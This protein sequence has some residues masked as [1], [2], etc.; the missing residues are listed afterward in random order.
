MLL[1]SITVQSEN[2]V[3]VSTATSYVRTYT[4]Y[5]GQF[6]AESDNAQG[7]LS[8]TCGTTIRENSRDYTREIIRNPSTGACSDMDTPTLV[9]LVEHLNGEMRHHIETS[10]YDFSTPHARP[11]LIGI[12]YGYPA[13]RRTKEITN[14]GCDMTQVPEQCGQNCDDEEALCKASCASCGATCTK[15]K[16]LCSSKCSSLTCP[17]YWQSTETNYTAEWSLRTEFTNYLTEMSVPT[18]TAVQRFENVFQ[19]KLATENSLAESYGLCDSKWTSLTLA[20]KT[21]KTPTS[22]WEATTE[23]RNFFNVEES[24]VAAYTDNVCLAYNGGVAVT[25]TGLLDIRV[26][27]S[28]GV[29]HSIRSRFLDQYMDPTPGFVFENY[30]IAANENAYYSLIESYGND[31]GCN[32]RR[33][34]VDRPKDLDPENIT[35]INI[36][37]GS[38]RDWTF[39]DNTGTNHRVTSYNPDKMIS[40]THVDHNGDEYSYKDNRDDGSRMFVTPDKLEKVIRAD[41]LVVYEWEHPN[42]PWDLAYRTAANANNNWGYTDETASWDAT[43]YQ[44][45]EDWRTAAYTYLTQ[46]KPDTFAE[47]DGHN[48]YVV[49][50]VARK[51]ADFDASSISKDSFELYMIMSTYSGIRLTDSWGGT[52]TAMGGGIQTVTKQGHLW[53]V[54]SLTD[55]SMNNAPYGN[56]QPY[57]YRGDVIESV[58]QAII[59]PGAEVKY[60]NTMA[61]VSSCISSDSVEYDDP[62][63]RSLSEHLNVGHYKYWWPT[64][65]MREQVG[66]LNAGGHR[67]LAPLR[68]MVTTEFLI[69]EARRDT[70][71]WSQSCMS[72][73]DMNELEY[74]WKM[75]TPNVSQY[76][77][78]AFTEQYK[79]DDLDTY[80]MMNSLTKI[81]STEDANPHCFKTI[82]DGTLADADGNWSAIN[83]FTDP[84]NLQFRLLPH[85]MNTKLNDISKLWNKHFIQKEESGWFSRNHEGAEATDCRRE[86]KSDS[87][88]GQLGSATFYCESDLIC[89]THKL[90][91]RLD[92]FNL[93]TNVYQNFAHRVGI[94]LKSTAG[95]TS[96]QSIF[97]MN[98]DQL[99]AAQT[100]NSQST[101]PKLAEML[102]SQLSLEPTSYLSD[103]GISM[104]VHNTEVR[105]LT[106]PGGADLQFA[107]HDTDANGS[108]SISEF[109][110]A[111]NKFGYLIN[112]EQYADIMRVFTLDNVDSDMSGNISMAEFETGLRTLNIHNNYGVVSQMIRQLDANENSQIEKEEFVQALVASKTG[113]FGAGTNCYLH[114]DVRN[115]GKF[116]SRDFP[117]SMLANHAYVDFLSNLNLRNNGNQGNVDYRYNFKCVVANRGVTFTVNATDADWQE[118]MLDTETTLSHDSTPSTCNPGHMTAIA[119]CKPGMKFSA[120]LTASVVSGEDDAKLGMFGVCNAS[121]AVGDIRWESASMTPACVSFTAF[122]DA[123]AAGNQSVSISKS[124]TWGAWGA[125]SGNVN[126]NFQKRLLAT[127]EEPVL[128]TIAI[129][130]SD[131]EI[132]TDDETGANVYYLP[133]KVLADEEKTSIQSKKLTGASQLRNLSATTLPDMTKS[134]PNDCNDLWLKFHGWRLELEG[135]DTNCSEG[136]KCK[137][138]FRTE[139]YTTQQQTPRVDY[140]YLNAADTTTSLGTSHEVQQLQVPQYKDIYVDSKAV[141]EHHYS[142]WTCR[143]KYKSCKLIDATIMS[144]KWEPELYWMVTPCTKLKMR[145]GIQRETEDML[146][147]ACVTERD[148]NNGNAQYWMTIIN[149]ECEQAYYGHPN[150]REQGMRLGRVN[151]GNMIKNPTIEMV[152]RNPYMQVTYN[153]RSWVKGT[154]EVWDFTTHRVRWA[155]YHPGEFLFQPL[156]WIKNKHQNSKAGVFRNYLNLGKLAIMNYNMQIENHCM[157]K[158]TIDWVKENGRTTV[159][160]PSDVFLLNE[161]DSTLTYT[162]NSDRRVVRYYRLRVKICQSANHEMCLYRGWTVR[163]KG[164]YFS[165]ARVAGAILSIPADAHTGGTRTTPTVLGIF[166]Y[167]ND[168]GKPYTYKTNSNH[169]AMVYVAA[170]ASGRNRN[171]TTTIGNRRLMSLPENERALATAAHWQLRY[172]GTTLPN[173]TTSLSFSLQV[174]DEN[175]ALISHESYDVPVEGTSAEF[176]KKMVPVISDTP[177]ETMDPAVLFS[178]IVTAIKQSEE[179]PFTDY[180]DRYYGWI[181][182]G[183]AVIWFIGGW[184]ALLGL[185]IV[186]RKTPIEE[187]SMKWARMFWWQYSLAILAPIVL[188][189]TRDTYKMNQIQQIPSTEQEIGNYGKPTPRLDS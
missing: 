18:L 127:T 178:A 75:T 84:N 100:F 4:T 142:N 184:G 71:D 106:A 114:V 171:L 54:Q 51:S 30:R 138:W 169:F 11:T 119:N 5:P 16:T 144:R 73:L 160:V 161:C 28:T 124:S 34:D 22:T 181:W 133:L 62:T 90:R 156:R 177:G 69:P 167:M 188:I 44:A 49:S 43:L 135:S 152:P 136:T 116:E 157:A 151:G 172:T 107:A 76:T 83:H 182:T 175:G 41:G 130:E 122:R 17:D 147:W 85:Q 3:G 36:C 78:Q 123:Y 52:V 29:S 148:D 55:C 31:A 131:L 150:K 98:D 56:Q 47:E 118:L 87:F 153:K 68:A 154:G 24:T 174:F 120:N 93:S 60:V 67:L 2:S 13:T 121:T 168:Q 101:N 63:A 53:I 1:K 134:T 23:T 166:P 105:D 186:E 25:S 14:L 155:G 129:D 39:Y 80:R 183:I 179:K 108:L 104:T 50:L 163:V 33:F 95:E 57:A 113:Q 185:Y 94:P 32:F 10:H 164:D 58:G 112:N 159:P 37:N 64:H 86:I 96:V 140:T 103:N 7:V 102:F 35:E 162:G 81:S 128:E 110:T 89:N 180:L 91:L 165:P 176:A 66:Q 115:D 40:T 125:W 46:I 111:M 6:T 59:C 70:I 117:V 139:F 92:S 137:K 48:G 145:E 143:N 99:Q 170:V 42:A 9:T 12:S 74:F 21:E 26:V 141:Q 109:L 27:E 65:W 146:R 8:H 88:C 38:H 173:G 77:Y 79:W 189:F 158:F 187:A 132:P 72:N 126:E 45:L 149:N 15:L 20:M 82:P 19:F 61:E 97:N